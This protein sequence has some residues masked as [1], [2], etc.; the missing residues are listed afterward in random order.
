MVRSLSLVRSRCYT[1]DMTYFLVTRFF[2]VSPIITMTKRRNYKSVLNSDLLD[3]I[4]SFAGDDNYQL[5][6]TLSPQR[7][8]LSKIMLVSREPAVMMLECGIASTY[9]RGLKSRVLKKESWVK[10][11]MEN[12][13]T[14]GYWIVHK[15]ED[16]L[17][18]PSDVQLL[19]KE[20]IRRLLKTI[21]EPRNFVFT[22]RR[23]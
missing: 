8:Y 14:G 19:Y 21:R 4:G 3:I 7:G 16:D 18:H 5:K 12:I 11:S 15:L 22:T 10:H 1:F 20:E 13:V 9:N 23:H 6:F 2:S 17:R